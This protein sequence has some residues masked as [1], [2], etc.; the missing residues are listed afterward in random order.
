LNPDKTIRRLAE[1]L[2]VDHERLRLW[3]FARAAAEPR[4]DWANGELVELARAIGP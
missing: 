1:K 2:D 3:T 4:A